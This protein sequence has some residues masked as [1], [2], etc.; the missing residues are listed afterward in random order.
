MWVEVSKSIGSTV[1]ANEGT[2]HSR[3][4]PDQ[5]FDL[6]SNRRRRYALH[7]LYRTEHQTA[8]IGELSEHVAA[9]ENDVTVSDVTS[10]ER[11]RVYTSL[12]QLH[13][14]RMDEMNVVEFDDRSGTVELGPAAD[15]LDVYLEVVGGRGVPWSQFYLALALVNVG[16]VAAVTVGAPPLT[17]LPGSAWAVFTATTFLLSAGVHSYY[18]HTEM[19][20]RA[21]ERPPELDG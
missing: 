10:A 18:N 2:G 4:S 19:Q 16:I 6:L 3:V 17:S 21:S 12:Q 11:K 9:W 1:A 20:L 13:L 7:H 14:P 15:D 8:E 5:G